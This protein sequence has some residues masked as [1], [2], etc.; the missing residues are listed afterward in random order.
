MLLTITYSG[1]NSTDLGYL[2]HKNP[3]RPQTFDLNRGRAWVFFPEISPEKTTCALL[4]E[5]DPLELARGK[6]GSRVGALF[7]YVND[8]PYVSSSFLSVAIAKVFGTAITGRSDERPALADSKLDLTA[9]V[10]M[11]PCQGDYEVIRRCFEPLGYEVEIETFLIDE[12]FPFWGESHLVN[13]TI[14]GNVL[15]RNLLKCL[16]VLIPIFDNKKHYF[17]N[18]EEVKKLIRRG[19][20]WLPSH[21]ERDFIVKRYLKK[22]WRLVDQAFEW[23]NQ[24]DGL[25][26][27]GE[28]LEDPEDDRLAQEDAVQA[29]QPPTLASLRNATVLKKLKSLGAKSVIDLGC[30]NGVILAELLKDGQ[31]DRLAGVDV[32]QVALAKARERLGLN[33]PSDSLVDRVALFLG[34]LTYFDERFLDYEVALAIEVIEHLEPSKV[35]A[36]EKVVFQYA[37]PKAVILTTPNRDYNIKFPALQGEFRH[38]DHRFEWSREEFKNWALMVAKRYGYQARIGEI[39][40]PDLKLGAPTLLGE[41]ALDN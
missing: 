20:E 21:P 34:A 8:R 9:T 36:F 3:Y 2:L 33:R 30:G 15:L 22:R 35:L 38:E 13:L 25:S 18:E 11:L 12:K 1:P 7:D 16:Y 4:L 32:S 14:R 6:N 19:A 29:E 27:Q 39:G 24:I 41:F 31:Y 10:T 28:A 26:D 40:T 37:R 17:I 5:L 23:L